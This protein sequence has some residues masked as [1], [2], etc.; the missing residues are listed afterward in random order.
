MVKKFSNDMTTKTDNVIIKLGENEIQL[1]V[2]ATA[3]YRFGARGG[4]ISRLHNRS[5]SYATCIDLL[6]ALLPDNVRA[7][8]SGPEALT[9]FIP[10]SD[11]SSLSKVVACGLTLMRL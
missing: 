7:D 3:L 9:Q 11:A 10:P 1:G 4:D 2:S 8:L 6:W 5:Q